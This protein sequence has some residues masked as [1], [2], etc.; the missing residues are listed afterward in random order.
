MRALSAIALAKVAV[1][2]FLSQPFIADAAE[3]K[4]LTGSGLRPVLEEIGPEFERSTKHKLAIEYS[5]TFSSKR[6]IEAGEAFDVAILGT[7]DVVDEL[8][9]QGK[10][11]GRTIIARTG[12]GV[13]MREGAQKPTIDS[14]DALKR[15]LLN[16]NSVAYNTDGTSA[17]H[18][19]KIFDRLGIAEQMKA[20]MKPLQGADRVAQSV[21]AGEAEL[22][23]LGSNIIVTTR[24]VQLAGLLPRDL[25]E[26]VVYTAGMSS[27]T[28]DANASKA[29]IDF[30]N[31][32]RATPVMKAKGL[33][34]F[35]P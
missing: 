4:L 33:E 29:L 35:A 2:V 25:Q 19:A 16:A 21:A 27:S 26:Y 34:R 20:K 30:L 6:K 5:S 24:G 11:V 8:V 18:M 12:I 3:I 15:T 31:S 14:A 23:L 10:L 7:P 13:A 22:A 32:E 1:V 17:K 9:K 28:K